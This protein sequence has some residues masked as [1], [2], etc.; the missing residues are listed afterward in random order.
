MVEETNKYKNKNKLIYLMPIEIIF[1]PCAQD[2][3][4]QKSKRWQGDYL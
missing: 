2:E 3:S 1:S 4:V